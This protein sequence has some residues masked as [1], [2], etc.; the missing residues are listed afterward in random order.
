MGVKLGEQ[1]V[2]CGRERV[3]DVN[4]SSQAAVLETEEGQTKEGALKNGH[5]RSW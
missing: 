1:Q 3:V 4:D 2:V 5:L